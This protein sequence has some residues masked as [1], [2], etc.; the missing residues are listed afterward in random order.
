MSDGAK[1]CLLRGHLSQRQ[2]KKTTQ[3]QGKKTE[4]I[5]NVL[6]VVVWRSSSNMATSCVPTSRV[7]AI[8]GGLGERVA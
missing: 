2:G 4:E 5:K 8:S 6:C 1:T 3:R 7:L